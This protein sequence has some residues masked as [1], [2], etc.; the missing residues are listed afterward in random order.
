MGTQS[1]MTAAGNVTL[2]V[3][4]NAVVGK[5]SSS[6]I[7]GSALDLTAGGAISANG[8]GQVN[9]TAP[10]GTETV[11]LQAGT[12]IGSSS[13]YLLV[14]IPEF[15]ASSTTGGIYINDLESA[16]VPTLSA[17]GGSI[18]LVVNGAL[19]FGTITSGDAANVQATGNITGNSLTTGNNSNAAV[20]STG[21]SITAGSLD[22]AGALTANADTTLALTTGQVGTT[23][24]LT[25]GTTMQIGT[26][27]SGGNQT[28]QAG[29]LFTLAANGALT[30]NGGGIGLVASGL[31]MGTQ[32]AMT[33]AGNVTLSVS[34]NAVV[35]KISSSLI[36]GSALDLTAGGA[37]SA[38]GDG[39][40][41]LTAPIGTE[42]VALQA[43]TGIGSSSA[44]L[45]VN[46]PEFTASSTT[47]GI[48]INDLESANVPTLSAPGGSIGLVV[49][50]A[51]AFGT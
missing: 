36:S 38:N 31:Q 33:A 42:T 30:S 7:S 11:A 29:N 43:G 20:T 28:L 22:I 48:Y 41:N 25:S 8:D 46:I 50:G 14:N 16:N 35:G 32:S 23:A 49:N 17:P 4:G 12:G 51:L 5:I 1:A 19:A 47:G 3:S 13:A 39:Q 27:T 45:L 21:G 10:I 34:G 37:I 15:T 2:S 18:G 44:Y 6:L 24:N 40:V 26:L 9:L